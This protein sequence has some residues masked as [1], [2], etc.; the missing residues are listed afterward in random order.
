MERINRLR[1][2]VFLVLFYIVSSDGI[3]QVKPPEFIVKDGIDVNIASGKP[4]FK[5]NDLKIGVGAL[6]LSHPIS[7][8]A[9]YFYGYNDRFSGGITFTQI[10]R[11]TA[12]DN[13]EAIPVASVGALGS[14]KN[15]E[16][17]ANGTFTDLRDDGEELIQLSTGNFLYTQKDGTEIT[18]NDFRMTEIVYPNGFTININRNG[19]RLISVNTNNGLQLKWVYEYSKY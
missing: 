5:V 14:T 18:Y 12:Q 1:T 19:Q 3:A 11:L 15:F 6:N 2:K 4:S 9:G 17:H 8:Y 13:S 7:S 10:N 16:R